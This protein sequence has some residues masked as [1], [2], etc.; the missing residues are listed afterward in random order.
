MTFGHGCHHP[1][2]V[3]N[4]WTGSGGVSSAKMQIA[5]GNE[6]CWNVESIQILSMAEGFIVR[7]AMN[8]V[9]IFIGI[10]ASN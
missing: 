1:S 3:L 9:F 6:T 7:G 10:M 8:D 2:R 5:H 4:Q